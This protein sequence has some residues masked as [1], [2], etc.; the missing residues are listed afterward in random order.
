LEVTRA[1]VACCGTVHEMTPEW[2]HFWDERWVLV[3]NEDKFSYLNVYD[4]GYIWRYLLRRD[5][6]N[7]RGLRFEPGRMIEDMPFAEHAILWA[8]KVV[9][10]PGAL[11]FYK[12]REN[13]TLNITR[14]RNREY[15][16]Q[17]DSEWIK[18]DAARQ[19]FMTLH[20]LESTKPKIQV[21]QY[22][23][24]GLPILMKR[25]MMFGRNTRW[26]FLGVR[27]IDTKKLRDRFL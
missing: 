18:A 4:F 20:G 3:S 14:R 19:E 6:I 15:V 8:N 10:V 11:Y 16:R 12:R 23:I 7:E 27:I 25:R 9:T 2:T 24:F 17:R 26:Y 1:D 13:S 22:K 5:F 21:W